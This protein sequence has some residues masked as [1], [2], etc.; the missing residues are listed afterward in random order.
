MNDL[1][2]KNSDLYTN[3]KCFFLHFIFHVTFLSPFVSQITWIIFPNRIMKVIA[4]NCWHDQWGLWTAHQNIYGR[5]AG[6]LFWKGKILNRAPYCGSSGVCAGGTLIGV[7]GLGLFF[8]VGGCLFV[9]LYLFFFF[10][11]RG[12]FNF[13]YFANNVRKVEACHRRELDDYWLDS[14]MCCFPSKDCDSYFP[15]ICLSIRPPATCP[16]V[17]LSHNNSGS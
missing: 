10:L 11:G 8:G 9:C 1:Y 3:V 2:F 5:G 15:N 12:I 17:C 16:P 13:I 7:G 14:V 6:I 4:E